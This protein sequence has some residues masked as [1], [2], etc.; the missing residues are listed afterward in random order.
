MEDNTIRNRISNTNCSAKTAIDQ[1]STPIRVNCSSSATAADGDKP[2]VERCLT[3][4][5]AEATEVT[6]FTTCAVKTGTDSVQQNDKPITTTTSSI[7]VSNTTSPTSAVKTATTS[8]VKPGAERLS[9]LTQA[10]APTQTLTTTQTLGPTQTLTTTQTLTPTQTLTTTP[11]P[12]SGQSPSSRSPSG[13]SP[14]GR[15]P[16]S[17]APPSE[18]RR[19]PKPDPFRDTQLSLAKYSSIGTNSQLTLPTITLTDLLLEVKTKSIESTLIPLVN[20][21]CTRFTS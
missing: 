8:G 16:T 11:S 14:T 9:V 20:Q 17:P 4:V 10:L 19:S 15:S 12:S 3:S 13:R 1:N 7:T 21:V 18:S 6:S 2:L 5:S